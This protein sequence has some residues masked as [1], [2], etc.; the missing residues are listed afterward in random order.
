MLVSVFIHTSISH[1]NVTAPVISS[2]Y[3]NYVL[4]IQAKASVVSLSIYFHVKRDE[5]RLTRCTWFCRRI[6]QRPKAQICTHVDSAY[7]GVTQ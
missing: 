3:L 2:K 4:L 5:N 1:H 7:I 6:Q